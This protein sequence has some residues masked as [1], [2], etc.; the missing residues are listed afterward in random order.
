MRRGLWF[1]AGAGAGIWAMA[2]AQRAADIFTSEGLRDRMGAWQVGAR[3]FRDEV[4]QGA[5]EREKQLREHLGLRPAGSPELTAPDRDG[6]AA[7]WAD[8]TRAERTGITDGHR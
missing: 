1:A 4:A 6:A 8:W 5:A 3:M 2:R 7:E